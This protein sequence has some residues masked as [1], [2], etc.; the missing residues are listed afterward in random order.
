M[1]DPPNSG[2]PQSP[3]FASEAALV[4][5]TQKSN[6]IDVLAFV[7]GGRRLAVELHSAEEV[8]TL[9]HITQV[10]L[11]PECVRG[12][13][14]LRGQLVVLVDLGSLL[15]N[16]SKERVLPGDSAVLVMRGHLRAG[17]LI[18]RIIDVLSVPM[19]RYEPSHRTGPV[20]GRFKGT[21]GSLDLVDVGAALEEVQ[22]RSALNASKLMTEEG[23]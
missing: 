22:R 18:D 13:T 5:D 20:A 6:E 15:D 14:N 21:A 7:A 23:Q 9:G 12:T 2:D 16:R 10:P 8:F 11:A 1:A 19:A 17:F 3:A 4:P